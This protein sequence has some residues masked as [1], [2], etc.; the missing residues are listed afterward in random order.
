MAKLFGMIASVDENMGRLTKLLDDLEI[1]DDTIFVFLG[2]NGTAQ[3]EAVFNAGMRG[4]KRSLYDGG[5]RVPLFFRWPAGKIGAPRDIDALTHVQD[6]FP[7]LLELSGVPAPAD[8]SFDG[9]RPSAGLEGSGTES[10]RADAGRAVRRSLRETSR[11][12]G[13]VEQVAPRQRKGVVR[14]RQ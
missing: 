9:V 3:G 1:A 4:K 11:C 8:A 10:D 2:D 13:D 12:R 6:I 7:T 5:H 14:N